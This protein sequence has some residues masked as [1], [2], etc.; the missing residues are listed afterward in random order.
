MKIK[1]SEVKVGDEFRFHGWLIRVT[2]VK[3]LPPLYAHWEDHPTKHNQYEMTFDILDEGLFHERTGWSFW[4]FYSDEE[5]DTES[6]PEECEECG[7][8]D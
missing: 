3:V 8:D 6:A 7:E 2:E 5:I 1:V 4:H